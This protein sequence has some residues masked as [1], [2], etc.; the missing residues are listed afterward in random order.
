MGKQGFEGVTATTDRRGHEILWAAL[1]REVAGDPAGVVRLGRYDV[2]AGTWS[3]YGYRLESTG[4]PGD[5]LG[6]SEITV[7]QDRLAVVERD[8][9]N[10][11]AAEVKR[12]YTVDLPTSAAPSGALRVLPKRLAHDVLPDLRATNGW[13]QEK[14]EG[15][16][17]G[18]DGHVY[19]VTD[20]DGLDDATG[21]TVFLDLGTERRVFGRRR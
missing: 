14:L 4:T 10:G 18:G 20:N 15:L 8:K 11:P 19:A 5:W 21:E 13:T 17:V 2:T 9:L 3:W 7:V 1:Q 6:L 16:T 12:I